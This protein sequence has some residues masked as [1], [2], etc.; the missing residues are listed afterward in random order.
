MLVV[1]HH[2][3]LHLLFQLPFYIEAF[4]SFYIFQVDPAKSRFKRFYNLNKFI[5]IGFGYFKKAPNASKSLSALEYLLQPE[6][7]QKISKSVEGR[8]VPVYKGQA[9]GEFW[10]KSKFSQLAQIAEN[11]RVRN[12][13]APGQA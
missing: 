2:R 4:W 3:N 10:E 9:K 12:W 7:L 13:P 1:V 6:N 11:G 5:R 8:F